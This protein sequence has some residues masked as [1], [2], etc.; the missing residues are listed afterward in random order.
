M[1]HRPGDFWGCL[2]TVTRKG[3]GVRRED[4]HSWCE[5]G[6]LPREGQG[7]LMIAN[8]PQVAEGLKETLKVFTN[9]DGAC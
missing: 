1:W 4:P 3:E 7:T 6:L 8:S 9:R 2:Q 5:H